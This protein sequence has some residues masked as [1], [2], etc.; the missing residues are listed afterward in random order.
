MRT[1]DLIRALASDGSRRRPSVGQTLALALLL[2]LAA[3]AAVFMVM[4]GPRP[5]IAAAAHT[6]RFLFKFVVTLA[7]AVSATA[8]VARL[9][10]PAARSRALAAALWIGPALLALGVVYELAAVPA[11]QW[12]AR[13]VG[14]NSR[15]CLS[16]IPLI[17]APVLLAA[18]IALR[19]GAPT[20]PA[21]AGA[22]AGL[23]A[24]G[25]GAT[26]Y[27]AHCTDDSP[28]F[29]MAWYTPAVALVVLVGALLG[30]RLL[31]W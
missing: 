9:A 30:A 14:T 7:L 24:G 3:A 31:R 28:L 26:L 16:S 23:L 20:R 4:L 29:V 5:D 22:V 27:A 13:L 19:R 25:F 1:D 18:I 2:G 11:S 17:A 10:R 12:A 15:V 8:L 6:P 21:L